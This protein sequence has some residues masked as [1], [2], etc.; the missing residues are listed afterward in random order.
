M[1]QCQFTESFS[2]RNNETCSKVIKGQT[3]TQHRAD[4]AREVWKLGSGLPALP[5]ALVVVGCA[6]LGIVPRMSQDGV[7]ST[8]IKPINECK[9]YAKATAHFF[10]RELMEGTPFCWTLQGGRFFC[11]LSL[12]LLRQVRSPQSRVD[13][14]A[15]PKQTLSFADHLPGQGRLLE[16]AQSHVHSGP[17]ATGLVILRCGPVS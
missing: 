2:K 4:A 13:G 15:M 1:V 6:A 9:C 10:K 5:R 12:D 3:F 7:A 11:D 16:R 8:S 17:D 14:G